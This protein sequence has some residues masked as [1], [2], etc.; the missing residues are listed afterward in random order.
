VKKALAAVALSL[1]V[2]LGL[3]V[4]PAQA[5]DATPQKARLTF[6]DNGYVVTPAT[7]TRG[8]PVEMEVDLTTVKGCMRTVVISAFGVNQTVKEG[9]T[10]IKFTPTKAGKTEIVCGMNHGRGSFTVVE[11]K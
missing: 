9:S 10:T 8:V 5:A 4:S 7:L 11:P 2:V 1:L 3:A 6:D